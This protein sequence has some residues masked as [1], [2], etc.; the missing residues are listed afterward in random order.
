MDV[1]G[2]RGAKYEVEALEKGRDPNGAPLAGARNKPGGGVVEPF[3]SR[4]DRA[5]RTHPF[6]VSWGTMLDSSGGIVARAAG[7]NADRLGGTLD[8]T[9]LYPLFHETLFGEKPP[10]R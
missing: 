1:I 9:G 7:L 2:L 6:V 8:N 5:G 3:V 4:P 10:G